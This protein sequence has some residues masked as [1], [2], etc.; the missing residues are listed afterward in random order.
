[1]WLIIT[2]SSLRRIPPSLKKFSFRWLQLE[3]SFRQWECLSHGDPLSRGNPGGDLCPWSSQFSGPRWFLGLFYQKCWNIISHE[4]FDAITY[5]FTT[6]D[7]PHGMNFSFVALISKIA[8]YI[9]VTDF[10]PIVI[11]NFIYKVYTKIIASRLGKFFHL[12]SLGLFRD[13]A[14]MPV[15]LLLLRPLIIWI[16]AGMGVWLWKLISLKLLT[17]S[18][19]VFSI[20]FFV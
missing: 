19:G 4:G 18:L 8:N 16:W 17:L 3:F 6:L 10:T 12:L 20:R 1:M 5:I 7:L 13:D 2:K 9:R 15:L 11:G 14:F